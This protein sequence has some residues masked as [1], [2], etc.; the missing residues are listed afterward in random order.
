MDQ[1]I[2]DLRQQLATTAADIETRLAGIT[3][4]DLARPAT[5]AGKEFSVRFVVHRLAAHAREHALQVRK[6]RRALGVPE[7]E[8]QMIVAQ[9]LEAEAAL[10]GETVGLTATQ[11]AQAPAEGEWSVKQVLEHLLASQKRF[12]ETIEQSLGGPRKA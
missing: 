1:S 2:R 5:Y 12:L 3:E 4:E 6:A 9:F 11:F 7:S 8:A 10:L